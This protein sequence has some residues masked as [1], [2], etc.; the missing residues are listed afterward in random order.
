M[1]SPSLDFHLESF[2]QWFNK[3]GVE[4]LIRPVNASACVG[5]V[6]LCTRFFSV[7]FLSFGIVYS[8][9]SFS[10]VFTAVKK[11]FF[12]ESMHAIQNFPCCPVIITH[13]SD[14]MRK[15][16]PAWSKLPQIVCFNSG[17]DHPERPWWSI[18]PLTWSFFFFFVALMFITRLHGCVCAHRRIAQVRW[19]CEPIA[20]K[21]AA[22][23]AAAMLSIWCKHEQ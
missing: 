15:K 4:S 20:K 22:P 17:H 9:R 12:G 16:P 6:F 8:S 3:E 21:S 13:C 19:K 2:L 5:S 18:R 10:G 23:G 11:L 1:Q 7:W 14:L